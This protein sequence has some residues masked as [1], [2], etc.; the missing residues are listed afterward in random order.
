[1]KVRELIEILKGCDKEATVVLAEDE[2]G[3]SYSPLAQW[4]E[5]FYVAH[6]A[7]T[8]DYYGQ[9]PEVDQEV[10]VLKVVT[11]WPIH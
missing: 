10:E 9:T 11:F 3:N 6:T 2:E 4:E 5:G 7:Y 8:G 1:M